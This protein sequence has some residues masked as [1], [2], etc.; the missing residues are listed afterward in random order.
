MPGFQD[1]AQQTSTE[2]FEEFSNVGPFGG[3]QSEVPLDQVEQFG[4][5][6]ILNMLLRRSIV[7]ARPGFTT[8]PALPAPTNEDIVGIADFYTNTS[9]RV[10]VLMTLTR[11]IQWNS[12]PQTFTNVPPGSGALT[13]VAANLFTWAVVNNTLCFCQGVDNLKGW[14]GIAGTFT[15]LSA[16]AFPAKFLMELATHLVT[17]STIEA[18]T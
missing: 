10:Q 17:A 11:L 4:Q 5:T 16:S 6:D 3:I 15:N 12:G 9:V 7:E 2:E 13:G 8:L 1:R 18:G 14:D